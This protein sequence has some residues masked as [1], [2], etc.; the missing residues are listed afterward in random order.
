MSTLV[1]RNVPDTLHARLKAMAER[2]RRSVTHEVITLIEREVLPG[3]RGGTGYPTRDR[4]QG[5][6]S[7]SAGVVAIAGRGA[8]R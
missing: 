4:G 7:R 1:I 8:L 5:A 3:G 2:N 6:A